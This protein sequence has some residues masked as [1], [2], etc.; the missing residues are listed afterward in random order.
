MTWT[1]FFSA[2][3]PHIFFLYGLAFFVLGLAVALELWRAEPTRFRQA[4][5][6]LA[7]FG[8]V[9]GTHEWIE[10][11]AIIGRQTY[12]FQPPPAF[13]ILRLILLAVSFVALIIFGIQRLYPSDRLRYSDLWIGL[14]ILLL[15][16]AGVGL[17]GQWLTWKQPAWF[18]AADVL[19]RYSLAIPGAIL[20]A[21]TFLFQRQRFLRL[22]QPGFANDLLWAALALLLYGVIGQ[23]FVGPSPLFPSN[24]LNADTFQSWF[25]IPIQL[26][27]G[28]M[29]VIVAVFTIR[30]LRAFE[31]NRQQALAAARRR[32]DEEI[33]QRDALRQ[34]FLHRVVE[35]QEEERTRIAR[36]LHD[37]LGQV[38][39]GLAIGLRGT[40]TS[41]TK[42]DLLQQQ[43][44]QLEEMAVQALN[45][46]RHLVNELR[47]ALLD[48]MGLPA[49]LRNYKDNFTTLTGI[50]TSLTMCKDY[51]RLPGEIETVLFR[52][53]QEALTNIARHARATHA[54]IDLSCRNRWVTLQI[55]DNGLGF[56]PVAVLDV[57]THSGW[58]LM[59]MQE[60]VKLVD[61]EIQIESGAG[62]GTVLTIRVP[63]KNERKK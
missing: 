55:K 5:W 3:I 34:E 21:W 31:Y 7:I 33:A 9:H 14:G 23:F 52:I 44:S 60:R 25:G 22:K 2:R 58:G 54:S 35:T 6:P 13:E 40:Q 28:T 38:L 27:R 29:A 46:M 49:A 10:M 41:V 32:V 37:E 11:F 48:D 61:G 12:A 63:L 51:N 20:A 57:D 30:A 50:Q 26:F 19:A 62:K 59:G 45:S 1:E 47:P 53:T 4:M 24:V 17:L 16:S 42:P 8:L 56:D 36:E 39:T 15:Y 18:A 43:L